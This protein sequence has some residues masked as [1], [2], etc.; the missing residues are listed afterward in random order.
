MKRLDFFMGALALVAVTV[1][2]A[3][4]SAFAQENGNRDVDGNIVRGPYETNKFGDNWFIGAGGGINVF[5]HDGYDM[6][7]APSIDASI[8]KWFTPSIGMRVGYQGFQ[9]KVWADSPSF[10]ATVRDAD[11]NE[12]ALKTGYMYIHGDFLWNMS[13]ALG[14]YK[15]TRFWNLIPYVHTGFYRSYGLDGADFADNEFALGAGLLHN[16]RLTNRLD[17]I[18]DMR[19]TAVKG[20]VIG[21]T[22]PSLLASVT[23]GLAVDLGWPAFVRTST[24][25][26][27]VEVA[28]M[29]RFAVMEAAALALEAANEALEAENIKLA[30]S[31]KNLSDQVKKLKKAGSQQPDLSEFFDGMAPSVFFEIGQTV[32][33]PKELKHLQ[34][35]AE[36]L[37][38]KAEEGTDIVI[39]V[40]GTADSNTGTTKRNQY[41]SDARGRYVFDILTK[42]YGISPERINV[43]SEVVNATGNPSFD[44]AVTFTF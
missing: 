15:E 25:L 10:L 36:S 31:N 35:I 13:N 12:Y 21:T 42:E 7:V 23:A 27:G 40:M 30:S 16:L 9:T 41:L 28:N 43:R 4:P 5:I 8:G 17:L 34:F 22:G 26:E 1:M 18:V 38:A 20:S 29:E 11:K 14:G 24:V 39:T 32:L 2:A 6:A 33:S 19:A 44:R 3:S 37:V